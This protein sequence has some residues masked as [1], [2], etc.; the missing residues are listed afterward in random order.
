MKQTKARSQRRNRKPVLK[1]KI[2]QRRNPRRLSSS[3]SRPP[4][5][6]ATLSRNTVSVTCHPTCLVRFLGPTQSPL[7]PIETVIVQMAFCGSGSSLIFA[8][9][10][11]ASRHLLRPRAL[12]TWRSKLRDQSAT[13]PA[14]K[15]LFCQNFL[16]TAGQF[17]S[18]TVP[19]LFTCLPLLLRRRA[20]GK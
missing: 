20:S 17:S 13:P 9:F 16:L 7:T 19:S 5:Q 8:L 2:R 14:S 1:T 6:Q 4:C 15:M 10:F 11:G 18:T 3:S 12:E